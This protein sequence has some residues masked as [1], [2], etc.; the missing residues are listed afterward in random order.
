MKDRGMDISGHRSAPLTL[1]QINRADY[2]FVMT[3][4]QAE[5]V[6]RQAPHAADRIRRIDDEDIQDPIG[7][8]EETYMEVA[9]RL[10]NAWRRRLKEIAL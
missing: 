3:A 9:E 1:E 4:D 10:D 8:T 6:R 5:A 2:I 7:A